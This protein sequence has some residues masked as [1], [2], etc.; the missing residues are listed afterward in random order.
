LTLC[1][2]GHDRDAAPLASDGGCRECQRARQRRYNRTPPR[3]AAQLA[4]HAS[5]DGLSYRRFYQRTRRV[6]DPVFREKDRAHSEKYRK[7]HPG[8]EVQKR[9]IAR[10][11]AEAAR[12]VPLLAAV[13]MTAACAFVRKLKGAV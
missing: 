5:P 10:K 6:L 4:Y 3:R 12:I 7:D 9:H 11:K 13:N 8:G 2:N 1:K